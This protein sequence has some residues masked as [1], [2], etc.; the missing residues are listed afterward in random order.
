MTAKSVLLEEVVTLARRLPP[1]DKL[2]LVERVLPDLDDAL[3]ED[4]GRIR[5]RSLLG[6]CA[7]LGSAPSAEDID[8]LRQEIW[9]GFPREGI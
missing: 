3:T 6:L 5:R 4:A 9:R 1:K 7:D 2:R 8:T